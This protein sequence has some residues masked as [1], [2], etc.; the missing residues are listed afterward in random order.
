MDCWDKDAFSNILSKIIYD[1]KK[2]IEEHKT[3]ERER[4]R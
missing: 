2:K 4:E 1:I 3:G